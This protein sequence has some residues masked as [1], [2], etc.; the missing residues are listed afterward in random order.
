MTLVGTSAPTSGGEHLLSHTLDMIAS[1]RGH[2]HD[3]HGRQVGVGTVLSAA[4]CER[5]LAIESPEF[6]AMPAQIDAGVWSGGAVADAVSRLYEAKRAGLDAVLR[7]LA[8]RNAWDRLRAELAV[9]SRRPETIRRW[10][11][12]AGA[13]TCA[14]DIA[15]STEQ[16]RD[17]ALHMHQIRRRFTVVDLAWMMG[18]LP[19]ALDDIIAQWLSG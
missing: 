1:V 16:L 9:R 10:L 11:E 6:C 2:R 8:E 4:L 18:V 12:R 13:A 19:G 14:A 3:L 5:I 15:C 7:H 17:A